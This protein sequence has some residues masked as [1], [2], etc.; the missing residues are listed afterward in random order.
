MTLPRVSI[1]TPVFN[2]A[3]YLAECIESVRSQDYPNL[4]HIVIDDG[5]TDHG[6]TVK[7]L[8]GYPHLNW[9]TRPNRGQYP[10]MNEGLHKAAGEIVC[11][12]SADD[13]LL[14]GAVSRAVE[15][16][17]QSTSAEGVYGQIQFVLQDGSDYPVSQILHTG[18][19]WL[20]PYFRFL[21]HASLFL[22]KS[23]LIEHGLLFSENLKYTGDYDWFIRMVDTDIRLTY[24][25][26]VFAKVR[27]H[28]NQSSQQHRDVIQAEHRAVL[29]AHGKSRLLFTLADK[30]IIYRGAFIRLTAMFRKKG[31]GATFRLLGQFL[32]KRAPF[33]KR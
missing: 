30:L 28:A 8:Q 33:F 29:S 7:I 11:F 5:S 4:E 27:L 18:P 12:F 10:T 19:G 23:S 26:E 9:W 22:R 14:P 2:G 32:K 20:Y 1:I 17:Q 3:D 15:A 24:I 25:P 21:S 13:L 6:E 31:P 16:L